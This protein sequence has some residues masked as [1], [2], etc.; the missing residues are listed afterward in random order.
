MKLRI[1]RT[2][3]Q[4]VAGEFPKGLA[5]LVARYCRHKQL[6]ASRE[7]FLRCAMFRGPDPAALAVDAS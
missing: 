5:K 3:A 4:T 1:E 6:G 7:V 2:L